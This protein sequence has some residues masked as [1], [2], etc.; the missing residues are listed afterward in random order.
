MRIEDYKFGRLKLDGQTY[1][2]D[3]LIWPGGVDD[4]W[5]RKKGHSLCMEDLSELLEKDF[6][7][8]IIG[9]GARGVMNVPRDVLEELRDRCDE[10]HVSTTEAACE[11][12]N[13]TAQDPDRR[14]AAALHLTC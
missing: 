1:T 7:V 2:S 10:V 12:F 11:K 9:T 6:D 13:E 3:V 4:S 14:V 8:L 5:W